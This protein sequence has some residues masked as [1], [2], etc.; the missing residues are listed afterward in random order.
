MR[1]LAGLAG[2]RRRRGLGGGGVL[3]AFS[4]FFGFGDEGGRSGF[5]WVLGMGDCL[6]GAE[7]ISMVGIGRFPKLALVPNIQL[8]SNRINSKYSRLPFEAVQDHQVHKISQDQ[9]AAI[10]SAN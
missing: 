5:F 6:R 3:G 7:R 9:Y 2:G 8:T 10:Q 4:C 1:R